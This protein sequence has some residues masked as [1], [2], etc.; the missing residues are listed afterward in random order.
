MKKLALLLCLFVASPA[1]A[2]PCDKLY[3]NS[4]EIVV[5]GTVVLCNTHFATVYDDAKNATVFS[6]EIAQER[7]KKTPR[8]DDFRADKRIADSPTPA[9]YTNTGYDRGH[10][11]AAA[12]ADD[13]IEMSETFLMTNM[14]PQLP[15]V[16]RV[17]WKNIE[18]RTRTLP[19]N[20]VITGA[21]YPANPKVIGKNKV[22]VPS[23]LYKI[24]Y[25]A[26]GNI[27]IYYVVNEPGAKLQTMS[28]SELRNL[29]GINFPG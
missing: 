3:P 29:T 8:T 24:V 14:T 9:D 26:S 13:P 5:P 11:A 19:F 2:S 17:V 22:P 6:T 16:N 15:N 25:L 7:I 21:T 1:F 10:M 4:T 23:A 28:I 18:E 20:H 27:A 12:N